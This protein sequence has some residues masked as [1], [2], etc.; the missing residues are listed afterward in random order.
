M[1]SE[2]A[3][4]SYARLSPSALAL[5]A[6]LAGGLAAA[7]SAAGAVILD[8]PFDAYADQAAFEATW[9]KDG[10]PI[11]HLDASFGNGGQSLICPSLDQGGGVTDRWTRNLGATYSGSDAR[12][13]VFSYD[14][15]LPAAGAGSSWEGAWQSCNIRGYSEGGY[16]LG[17]LESLIGIGVSKLP[18]SNPAW[19]QAR[20]ITRDR[21]MEPLGYLNLDAPGAPVRSPGWHHLAA[22]VRSND[23]TMLVD[24]IAAGQVAYQLPIGFNC[25]VLGNGVTSTGPCWIDNVRLEVVPEPG[26][27][28]LL[29]L[30][31]LALLG[32][33]SGRAQL[34]NRRG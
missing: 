31:G 18:D 19:Y 9:S 15:Y 34:L 8:E 7:S 33:W 11:Y 16:N 14:L 21:I 10:N 28:T 29:A 23:M 25:V 3:R 20:V 1:Q 17:K 27:L 13:L 2:P 22:I 32:P 5:L 12:P 6:G 4:R 30:A 24:G 26:A